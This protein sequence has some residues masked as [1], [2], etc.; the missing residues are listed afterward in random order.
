AR[1]LEENVLRTVRDGNIGS[2]FGLG[3][4]PWSGGALQYINQYGV[5]AFV[6]R[7]HALAAQFGDRF[8]PPALLV[9]AAE[10]QQ[11]LV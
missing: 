8:A 5:R 4:A 3:F 9:Q 11:M 6:E 2:I 10:R 1:C 7:A